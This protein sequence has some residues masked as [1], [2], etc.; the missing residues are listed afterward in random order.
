MPETKETKITKETK[1]TK[2]I[3]KTKKKEISLVIVESPAKEKTLSKFLG[4]GY[5]VKSSYGHLRDLP[6]KEFGLDV[7]NGFQP[8]YTPLT[9]AKQLVPPLKKIS[10]IAARVYLATDYDREGE[11]I[12][13]HLSQ[14][15]ELPPEKVK[16]ITF[17]EITPEAIQ[18]AIKTPRAIDQA[19]VDAQVAR[20]ALDRIV[21]YK[22]SPLLWEKVKRGLSA[23]RVQS[24]AVKLIC[25]REDEIEKF[26]SQ[27]Y[28]SLRVKLENTLHK[29]VIPF[30]ANLVEWKS[31]KVEKLDI[32]NGNQ[33]GEIDAA[34]KTG[35]YKVKT[36]TQKEKKRS[37]YPP[38]M[39]STMAQ[40]ASRKLGFTAERTMRIAQMLYEGVE[41]NKE[42]VGLIT[43][44]R[45]D[46]LHVAASAQK[47]ALGYIEKHYGKEYLPEKPRHYKSKSKG[48]QEA[49]EAVR[50]TSVNRTPASLRNALTAE[51]LRLYQLIWNRFVAS[52]M[53]DA[54]FDTVTVEIDVQSAPNSGVLRAN[55]STLKKTGFLKVYGEEEEPETKTADDK[56]PDDNRLPSLSV[57]EKLKFIESLS[58]QHFT[59]PPPRYNEASLIKVLELNGI[60]RPST[61]API[62]KTIISR[63]YVRIQERKIIPTDLGRIVNKQLINHF[64]EIVDTGFTAKIEEKLDEVAE[65]GLAWQVPVQEFYDAFEKDLAEAQINM[66][67][68]VIELK[69][70]GEICPLDQGKL[71]I[72][73][74][75]FGK[76]LSCE[77][78]PKC[79]HKV[80]LDADGKKL[81]PETTDEKCVKCGSPMAVKMGRRGK[82][83]ACTAY[84]NC[85]NIIGIDRDGNKI[86]RPAPE[87]TDKKCDKCGSAML[88]RFGKRGPFLA[89][90]AFPKCR[91][92][93]KFTE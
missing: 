59:E 27:E 92:I 1:V 90:S 64:P 46:S 87:M 26:K 14:I 11:S 25:E 2:E 62:I 7:K 45:T 61:Y 89:C 13:W 18:H 82:F 91:N 12:A 30:L 72:R 8:K 76:Y 47:E 52:Q 23:G 24:A 44:M 5:I 43:Y 36:V 49:H 67:K 63:G 4:D 15:L 31:K 38:F 50:P 56:A 42:T 83:L 9:R 66:A 93:K 78:F 84:P 3:K 48:A 70:S 53:T 6:K 32:A 39:T 10:K 34:L 28:W 71:L 85:R 35:A 51:Q 21:G 81:V 88:K 19:L 29:D 54:I 86:I 55:G 80:S 33:A 41:M 79:K 37:P 20:R 69:D 22:L 73:E 68:V 17:H 65:G 60:G 57:D 75:R 16:R 74:S 40:D 77:N 58:E